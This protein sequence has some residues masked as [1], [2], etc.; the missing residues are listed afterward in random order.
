MSEITPRSIL[1][2]IEKSSAAQTSVA[3]LPEATETPPS[4]TRAALSPVPNVTP[5][6]ESQD[7]TE[8]R[9]SGRSC[10]RTGRAKE[11]GYDTK[12]AADKQ[13]AARAKRTRNRKKKR[14]FSR[15]RSDAE[16]ATH[17]Y[18][19]FASEADNDG[20]DSSMSPARIATADE[21]EAQPTRTDIQERLTRRFKEMVQNSG[22]QTLIEVDGPGNSKTYRQPGGG[23]RTSSTPRLDH[24]ESNSP[25]QR[26]SPNPEA[27]LDD[28]Q[29]WISPFSTSREGASMPPPRLAHPT[30]A[31]F[32]GYPDDQASRR[33]HTSPTP[34]DNHPANSQQSHSRLSQQYRSST[35][36]PRTLGLTPSEPEERTRST[37]PAQPRG[38]RPL[39]ISDASLPARKR[40]ATSARST[41]GG[42]AYKGRLNIVDIDSER[43]ST[44]HTTSRQVSRRRTARRK[45]PGRSG[46]TTGTSGRVSPA[47]QQTGH[48]LELLEDFEEEG[49]PVV[50]AARKGVLLEPGY[51][52]PT[53]HDLLPW[54]LAVWKYV[55]D[56][57]WALSMGQGNFQTRV[58]FGS[59][60]DACFAHIRELKLP[61]LPPTTIMSEDMRTVILNNL[62]NARYQD[63]LRLREPVR[64]FFRF[65]NPIT[66]GERRR[67]KDKVRKVY[68]KFFHY[69]D[70][71]NHVDPYEGGI[72]TL[73]LE[74]ERPPKRRA[75]LAVLAYLATMVQFCLGEW[76]E[77]YFAKDKLN[78]TKQYSVWLCH[79]DGLKNVSL[80][81]RERLIETYNQWVRDAYD[82]SQAQTYFSDKSYVQDVVRPQDVRPD[83]PAGT[84]GPSERS[85]T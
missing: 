63:L 74:S 24:A 41:G 84:P 35:P 77:G 42:H 39:E 72:L 76:T 28:R 16:S 14:R 20:R 44:N 36:E 38:K 66:P 57:V 71:D 8:L 54:Q 68:P 53:T 56:L 83:T 46:S 5:P 64:G 85:E 19:T 50:D 62:C 25:S 34:A 2:H 55:R 13:R 10:I 40:I 47:S 52:K 21:P 61:D 4:G 70:I 43:V 17:E 11:G 67:N 6:S 27:S 32:L 23:R 7:Q 48:S 15:P 26:R 59:W 30:D 75:Q 1:A 65:K 9:R 69:K 80:V 3:A 12:L 33:S 22:T 73:A 31:P 49:E 18:P 81:A 79:F 60:A 51:R 78:A 37:T 82:A 29:Y 45:T 58:V